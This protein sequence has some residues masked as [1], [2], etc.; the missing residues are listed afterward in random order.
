MYCYV[1]SYVVRPECLPA[2]RT[3]YGPDGDWVKLFQRD[4][5]YIRTN[6]LAILR[7][8]RAL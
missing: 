2:F 5:E 1:W 6:F 8:R 4:P 7:T 3:A